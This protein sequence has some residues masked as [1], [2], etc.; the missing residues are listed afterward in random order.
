MLTS[1]HRIYPKSL[2]GSTLKF[3]GLF[4]APFVPVSEIYGDVFRTISAAMGAEEQAT[5][6]SGKTYIL[7]IS[8]KE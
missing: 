2:F 4:A 8:I 7:V 1:W 3:F 6:L 5:F